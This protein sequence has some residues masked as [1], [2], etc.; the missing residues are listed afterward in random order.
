MTPF[1]PTK[2]RRGIFFILVWDCIGLVVV[3]SAENHAAVGGLLAPTRGTDRP[4]RLSATV[5]IGL[6]ACQTNDSLA[7]MNQARRQNS[8]FYTLRERLTRLAQYFPHG[9]F[10]NDASLT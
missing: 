5:Q 2:E 3:A 6:D 7:L 4:S 8:L 1:L 10:A 9:C